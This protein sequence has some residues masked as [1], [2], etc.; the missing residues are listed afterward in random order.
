MTVS[1]AIGGDM[2]ENLM[3]LNYLM[4]IFAKMSLN[5]KLAFIGRTCCYSFGYSQ[6]PY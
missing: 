5:M 6:S 4:I 3:L 2:I 1:V